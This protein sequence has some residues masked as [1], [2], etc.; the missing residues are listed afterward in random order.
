V[1]DRQP[2]QAKGRILWA[3]F[4]VTLQLVGWP[5]RLCRRGP[6]AVSLGQTCCSDRLFTKA[7]LQIYK[8]STAFGKGRILEATATGFSLSAD[9]KKY[10][11]RRHLNKIKQCSL[12]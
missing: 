6:V 3:W 10:F 2:A 5:K 4:F 1:T 12:L 8:V 9:T 11:C 7:C